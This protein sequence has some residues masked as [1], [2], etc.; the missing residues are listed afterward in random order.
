[1][2]GYMCLNNLIIKNIQLDYQ[3]HHADRNYYYR[4]KFDRGAIA[5]EVY[6]LSKGLLLSAGCYRCSLQGRRH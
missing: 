5:I 3:L 1:M 2:G 6:S 4:A